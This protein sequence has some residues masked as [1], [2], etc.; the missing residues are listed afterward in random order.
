MDVFFRVDINIV[1]MILL[2]SVFLIAYKRLDVKDKLNRIFLTTSSIIILELF[3]E[4]MTCIINRRPEKWLIPISY[5]LH[6]CLF[7][8]GPALACLW[9]FFIC[10]WVTPNS[11]T[12]QKKHIALIIP[13]LANYIITIL[14]PIY[15]FVFYIDSSNVYHRGSLFIFSSAV[16]YFYMICSF[17]PILRQRNKLLKQDFIPIFAFG[18]FP[19]IGGVIQTLFYGVLLMWSSIAFSMVMMYCLLQQRMVQ[20]DKL[21]G[22]WTRGTFD[23]YI[24]QRVKEK[25][26][27]KFGIMFIDMDGLKKINDIYGHIEGDFAIKTTVELIQRTLKRTDIVARYGGDEF[28]VI[29]DCNSENELEENVERIES[30]FAQYNKDSIKRY[31]LKYSCGADIFDPKQNDI[32]KFLR[33]IDK[34]MYDNKKKKRIINFE[35]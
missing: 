18:F 19:I 34:L 22:A 3:F 10:N 14:S 4:T 30:C 27:S 32:E 20:L 23:Y 31:K 7:V 17:L 33:H 26:S 24:S 12:F 13:A 11:F 1:S 21:T 35:M 9:Y 5:F 15:G 16:I 25:N 8:V 2:G 29:L 28:I 6:L